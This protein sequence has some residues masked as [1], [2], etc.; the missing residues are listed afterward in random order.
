MCCVC[1]CV[2]AWV[3]FCILLIENINASSHKYDFWPKLILKTGTDNSNTNSF[4]FEIGVYKLISKVSL[5]IWE[6]KKGVQVNVLFFCHIQPMEIVMIKFNQILFYYKTCLYCQ[7]NVV[8]VF[9][10]HQISINNSSLF[11]YRVQFDGFA[12]IIFFSL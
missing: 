6:K 3:I 7:K 4:V 2:C 11:I 5:F 9:W 12:N 1:V 10:D 8:V